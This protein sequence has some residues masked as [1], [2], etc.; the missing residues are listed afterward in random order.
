MSWLHHE[1]APGAACRLFGISVDIDNIVGGTGH[2]SRWVRRSV[3]DEG[4]ILLHHLA[5]N[6]IVGWLRVA[7][8]DDATAPAKAT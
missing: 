6:D 2:H 1:A 7:A 3:E 8:W 5:I 4:G